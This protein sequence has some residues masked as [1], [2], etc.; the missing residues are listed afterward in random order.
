MEVAHAAKL[1]IRSAIDGVSGKLDGEPVLVSLSTVDEFL[2][3]ISPKATHVRVR[4]GLNAVTEMN[5]GAGDAVVIPWAPEV[6]TTVNVV[7][8]G[9]A[10]VTLGDDARMSALETP[11]LLR[12]DSDR[13]GSELLISAHGAI[14]VTSIEMV[15]RNLPAEGEVPA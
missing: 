1:E 8:T 14:T 5:L 12:I 3:E 2:D 11:Q 10:T 6:A 7:V 4:S 15:P 13:G 9:H